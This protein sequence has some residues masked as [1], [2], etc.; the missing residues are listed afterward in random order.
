MARRRPPPPP[1]SLRTPPKWAKPMPKT[2]PRPSNRVPPWVYVGSPDVEE[3]LIEEL[4]PS[5]KPMAPGVV[6]ADIDVDPVFATQVLPHAE[7]ITTLT[8][9][10]LAA[11]LLVFAEAAGASPMEIQI[12]VPEMAR[13]GSAR[14]TDHP[15]APDGQRLRETLASKVEGRRAKGKMAP[16]TR[17]RLQVLLLGPVTC[18]A[19]VVPVPVDTDPLLAWPSPFSAGRALSEKQ[20]KNA[21]SSAHRKLDEALAWLA[22]DV[23]ANDVVVDLGAAPGGWTRVMRDKGAKVIAVDRAALDPELVKDPGVTHLKQD[24]L[25]IDLAG[26]KASIV[27]CDVIWT[28]DNALVIAD[29][30]TRTPSARAAVITLKLKQPIDWA[31]LKEAKGLLNRPG[32]WNGRI[33]HL[34]ANKLE[35]TLLLRRDAGFVTT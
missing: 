23:T 12:D 16:A 27:L 22:I 19:A 21:P 2:P 8:H 11:A 14:K 34:M 6:G 10:E 32:G 31:T 9:D 25:G 26:H 24:A 1:K 28:P 29:R 30:V 20:S 7:R 17:H 18:L 4:G 5:A 33:K 35:V 15:L 3:L 13:L